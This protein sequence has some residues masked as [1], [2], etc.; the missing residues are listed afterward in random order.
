MGNTTEDA[1]DLSTLAACLW[2]GNIRAGKGTRG[3]DPQIDQEHFSEP[4][5]HGI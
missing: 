2:P 3:T 4:Y 1:C 5:L